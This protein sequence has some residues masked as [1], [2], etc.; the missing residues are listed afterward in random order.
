MSPV[1][2]TMVRGWQDRMLNTMAASAEAKSASLTPKNPPV[3]RYMSS[4]NAM[5][6]RTLGYIRMLFFRG[7]GG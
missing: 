7:Y 2:P 3:R 6:G 4:V 5:A 1:T